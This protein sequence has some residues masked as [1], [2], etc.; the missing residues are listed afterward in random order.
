MDKLLDDKGKPIA[1]AVKAEL[2]RLLALP[3]EEIYAELKKRTNT[4]LSTLGLASE[5]LCNR[6]AEYTKKK[7]L[8][9]AA[10]K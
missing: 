7:E 6:V 4:E 5:V 2:K 1:L 8:G 9:S 10:K 3:D